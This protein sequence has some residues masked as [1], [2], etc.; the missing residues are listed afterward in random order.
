MAQCPLYFIRFKTNGFSIDKTRRPMNHSKER[1]QRQGEPDSNSVHQDHRPY[2]KRA[3]R[4]VRVWIAVFVMIAGM[5]VYF[6][7]N[8]FAFLPR[9][10]PPQP[11]SGTLPAH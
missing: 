8:D 5:I 6:M 10:G 4:D 9:S 2:W 3:H 1:H 11:I 7:S